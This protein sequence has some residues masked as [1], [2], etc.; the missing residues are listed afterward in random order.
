MSRR[1]SRHRRQTRKQR[2][3][4]ARDR[5]AQAAA[6]RRQQ[7]VEA[8]SDEERARA[9]SRFATL[10]GRGGVVLPP[11]VLAP[12]ASG[13]TPEDLRDNTARA[14]RGDAGAGTYLS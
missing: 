5:Q 10:R 1:S 13:M 12:L 7:P 11:L 14:G 4:A 2:T 9:L 8:L 6:E 3:L